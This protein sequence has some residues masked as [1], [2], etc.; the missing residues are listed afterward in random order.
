M[1][2]RE[3]IRVRSDSRRRGRYL[4]GNPLWPLEALRELRNPPF[5]A[6]AEFTPFDI[7]ALGCDPK[8]DALP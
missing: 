6:D 4:V 7:D 3:F 1:S 5:V 2:Q 8:S